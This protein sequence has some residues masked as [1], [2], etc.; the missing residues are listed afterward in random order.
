MDSLSSVGG[1]GFCSGNTY[2]LPACRCTESA[3]GS[4]FTGEAC[5]KGM[6]DKSAPHGSVA[7]GW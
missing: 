6:Y 4:L 3:T 1:K 7:L 2:V 5:E